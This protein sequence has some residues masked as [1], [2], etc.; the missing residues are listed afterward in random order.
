MALKFSNFSALSRVSGAIGEESNI[1]VLIIRV[2]ALIFIILSISGMT[3]W[4]IGTSANNDYVLAIDSSA[5]MMQNDFSPNR[6]EVAKTAANNF[7]DNLPFSSKV[8]IV[9]FSGVSFVNQPLTGDKSLMK[10]AISSINS[11]AIGGTDL[12]G[13]IITSTNLLIPSKKS[14]MIILLTDG[15]S[16][17]GISEKTGLSYALD[18]HVVVHTIGIGA[19]K[20]IDNKTS[21]S[22]GINEDTLKK[23]AD[24]TLG[25]YYH[26]S[27]SNDLKN[28]YKNIVVTRTR[29]RI[30][31]DFSFPLLLV[32]LGL[33]IFDWFLGGTIYRRIV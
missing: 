17:I 13:A 4:Y 23:M 20:I 26:A 18:N 30:P 5:S 22:L 12:G 16:N 11:K 8:A 32:S 28:I 31:F 14:R 25:N 29:G 2:A 21:L 3:L 10:E 9:S 7:V 15:R 27:N 19:T 33:L 1:P 6:L 24:L